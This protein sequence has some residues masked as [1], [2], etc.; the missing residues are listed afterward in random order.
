M[1]LAS[2]PFFIA[3]RCAAV[4]KLRRKNKTVSD[5]GEEDSSAPKSPKGEQPSGDSDKENEP[6]AEPEGWIEDPGSD[7]DQGGGESSRALRKA[8]KARLKQLED[9]R[10]MTSKLIRETKLS[11]EDETEKVIQ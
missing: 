10:R 8:E 3:L 7:D 9:D 4:K 5:D 11:L 2:R 6:E 1:R